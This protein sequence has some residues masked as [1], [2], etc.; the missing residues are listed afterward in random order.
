MSSGISE[1]E[2][3]GDRNWIKKASLK[4]TLISNWSNQ[5]GSKF[6]PLTRLEQEKRKGSKCNGRPD[7]LEAVSTQVGNEGNGT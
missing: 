1:I 6:T 3:F 2:D 7:Q 5:V 4:L